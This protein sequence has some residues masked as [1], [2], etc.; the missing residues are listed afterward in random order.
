MKTDNHDPG[1]LAQLIEAI[2]ESAKYRQIDAAIVARIGAEELAKGRRLKE[3]V[4]ETK[5]KLHQVGGA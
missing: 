1:Q 2:G 3:A 4:K 5:N